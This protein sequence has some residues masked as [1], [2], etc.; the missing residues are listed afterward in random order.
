M[1]AKELNPADKFGTKGHLFW[2][3]IEI[4]I[5][6]YIYL[7]IFFTIIHFILYLNSGYIMSAAFTY[8]IKYK[9]FENF[10]Y[11]YIYVVSFSDCHEH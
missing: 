7:F 4:Y 8:I 2:S 10:S 6:M 1:T 3:N 5:A 9:V 11:E